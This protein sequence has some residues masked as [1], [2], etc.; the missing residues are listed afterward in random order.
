MKKD[1][2]GDLTCW[3]EVI[4]RLRNMDDSEELSKCQIGLIRILQYKGNWR[5]RE[6]VLNRVGD[7]RD[8]SRE[9]VSQVLA[10]LDDDNTY[11]DA[12]IMAGNAL[13]RLL[14]NMPDDTGDEMR[15]KI[16]KA[17][18]RLRS[19]PQPPF[20]SEALNRVY[21]EVGLPTTAEQ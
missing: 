8:P 9:L 4:D 5:L 6:T 15:Q 13:V 1:P 12:R 14:R 10:V 20:F 21:S 16:R 18:R 2:F 7:L 19:T 3:G 17:I 11:Y